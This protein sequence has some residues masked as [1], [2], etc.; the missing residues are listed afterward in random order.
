MRAS[1]RSGISSIERMRMSPAFSRALRARS[2]SSHGN[3]MI[4]RDAGHLRRG[5]HAGVGAPGGVQRIVRADDRVD[6]L[7]EDLPGC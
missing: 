2:N 6:L 3:W 5:V 4:D 1:H 7:F